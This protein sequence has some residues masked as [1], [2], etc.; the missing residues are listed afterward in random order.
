MSGGPPPPGMLDP[1]ML[2]PDE[3]RGPLLLAQ[4][5]TYVAIGSIMTAL[6]FFARFKIRAV[7]L[8]DWMMLATVILFTISTGFVTYM[9]SIGGSRHVFYLTPEQTLLAVKYSW[10]SQPWA[11]FTFATGKAS[12]AFLTLRIIGRNTVWRKYMLWFIIAT[13]TIVNGLGCIITFVQCDPPRALWTPE[14]ALTASCWDPSVQ[15]HYNYFL[16][17]YN[18]LVDIVLAVLPATFIANLSLPLKKKVALCILLSLG[19]IAAICSGLKI[20]YLDKLGARTDFTWNAYDIQVWTGAECFIMMVCGNVPPLQLLWDRYIAHTLD[21]NWTRV[22]TRKYASNGSGSG[23]SGYSYEKS[24]KNSR[25][26]LGSSNS[27]TANNKSPTHTQI[28]TAGEYDGSLPRHPGNIYA[29]TN[30]EV[31]ADARHFV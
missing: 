13:I 20:R 31:R 25:V 30:V 26:R 14:L 5:W 17:A 29:T 2:P 15:L 8:D 10:I 27:S 18:I 3:D 4:F 7:G 21:A 12:V 11:I 1:S 22:S 24:S 9:A 6:R 16:S 23:G 19:F 28:V